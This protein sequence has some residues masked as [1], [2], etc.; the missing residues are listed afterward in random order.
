MFISSKSG[1]FVEAPMLNAGNAVKKLRTYFPRTLLM[2]LAMSVIALSQAQP[3]SSSTA[4]PATDSAQPA[5][6]P[7]GITVDPGFI[8]G[9]DDILGVS[10][11][12][13]PDVSRTVTVRSDGKISLPLVGELD[14]SGKTPK[15]LEDEIRTKLASYISDPEVTLI[16]QEIRSHRYNVLGM[17]SHPGSYVLTSTTT[18]LDAIAMS[19][20]FRDFAK[21]KAIYVLRAN[22]DGSKTRLPFNYREVVKGDKAKQN[23]KLET[24]DTV[25]VP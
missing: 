14:A 10:V 2:F 5:N 3:A 23:I 22:P 21:Q 18:V 6:K 20:G 4:T 16:V 12:K 15:Q 1:V 24:G 7:V 9:A 8:I 13:E 25:V 11:W 17:V 19:G